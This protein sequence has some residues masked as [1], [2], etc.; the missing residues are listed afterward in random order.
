MKRPRSIAELARVAGCSRSHVSHACNELNRSGWLRFVNTPNSRIAVPAF[1]REVEDERIEKLL[2]E[3]D[4]APYLG[5]FLMRKLLDNTVAST[6]FMDNARPSFLRNPKTN[7]PLE[8][9]R[10]YFEGLLSSS[11][12]SNTIRRPLNFPTP[13]PC[14]KEEPEIL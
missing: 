10:L 6:T 13:K 14:R 2:W 8:Y 9:D 12:V 3:K 11:T 7:Q 4:M 1:P 5:E